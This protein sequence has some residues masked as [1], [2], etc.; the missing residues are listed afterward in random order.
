[1]LLVFGKDKK[2]LYKSKPV[3]EFFEFI[4]KVKNEG[5]KEVRN[6]NGDVIHPYIPPFKIV[7]PQDLSSY[8]KITRMGGAVKVH[9]MFYPMCSC[10]SDINILLTSQEENNKCDRCKSNGNRRCHHWDFITKN[11]LE[12]KRKEIN[13]LINNSPNLDITEMKTRLCG[14]KKKKRTAKQAKQVTKIFGKNDAIWKNQIRWC[15][16]VQFYGK[17]NMK[18]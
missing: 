17:R 4:K 6:E 15:G 11:T 16:R 10:T 13:K 12:E 3:V 8:W 5:L 14:R 2:E 1:M 18:M 7:F 9:D